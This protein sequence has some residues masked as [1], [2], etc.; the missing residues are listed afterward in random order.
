VRVLGIETSS[1]RGSVAL[2]EGSDTVCALEHERANAHGE[3]ILPLV[4]RALALA[5]WNRR[6][7]DRIAVGSG[8]GSFTGLRVG[9]AI[10]QGLSEGLEVPL[11]GIP[12]LRAMALAVP[13]GLYG[14]RCVLVDARRGE[15]FAAAYDPDGRERAEVR[16]V[17]SVNELTPLLH[18]L[19]DPLFIGNGVVSLPASTRVFRSA[20][21]D[22]PHA[23]WTAIAAI[24]APPMHSVRPLYVRDAGAVMPQLPQNP[25]GPSRSE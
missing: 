18:A 6:Q 22:L 13:T 9:I 16:L 3:S 7:L 2:V 4:E 5:G 23:R 1:A 19:G 24:E 15:L 11:V 20:E 25:L 8:P 14:C 10:A 12:S 17:A 21:T